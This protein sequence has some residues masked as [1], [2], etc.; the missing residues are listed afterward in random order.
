[1]PQHRENKGQTTMASECK[2]D[3]LFS[4]WDRP[5]SPGCAVGVIQNGQLVYKRGYGMANLEHD[6]PITSRTVFRIA[7]TSKQFTAMCI[8]LLAEQGELSLDDDIRKHLPEMPKYG[9]TITI[10]HLIHHTSGLYDY[11]EL[12]NL[13]G[14]RDED[15]CTDDNV[16][17][18][19]GRQ[20]TLNFTPGSEYLYSNTGYYLLGLIVK[21]VSG[22]SLREFA[23]ARIFEPLGMMDTQFHDDHTAVVKHRAAGYSPRDDG[24]YRIDMTAQDLVGDGGLF[25]TVEDLYL[26]DQNFNH[27][28]LG[29]GNDSL[30]QQVL[31]PGVLNSG[32]KLGYAFG[33]IVGNYRG[34][35]T[36]SH[37]G[38]FVGF[39]AEVIRF[40]E[41]RFSVICLANLSTINPE[42]L[43]RQIADIYLDG[44]FKDSP[45]GAEPIELPQETLADKVGVYRS[46]TSGQVVELSLPKGSLVAEMSGE[47]FP[48]APTTE[49]DFVTV[50]APLNAQIRFERSGQGK[51]WLMHV[52][53]E[54]E[55]AD[56][57]EMIEVVSPNADRLAE[58]VG[59]YHSKELQTTY[60]LVIKDGKLFV[61]HRSAPRD[62][63]KP[64]VDDMFWAEAI[65]FHFTRDAEGRVSGFTVSTERARKIRFARIH[66]L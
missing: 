14:T 9:Y 15:P 24:G 49:T 5:D 29:A 31:T 57:L 32:E 7:S 42:R 8:A 23:E 20:E 35:K 64:G 13:A 56:T 27:N 26:W 1:M 54:G 21:R 33:L 55:R 34:L 4:E 11:V 62:P 59:D 2:V 6:V 17:E 10:W 48:I 63:L 51:L 39:R 43:A 12:M 37:G 16:I 22:Q 18:M 25:T 66:S 58:Y 19:L 46:F 50:A 65:T 47:R 38:S 52:H 36:V 53:V 40:P 30:V 61:R 41:R 60:R 45:R 3:K 44:E 28:R